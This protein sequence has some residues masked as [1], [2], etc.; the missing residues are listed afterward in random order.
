MDWWGVTGKEVGLGLENKTDVSAT[1][2]SPDG[3]TPPRAELQ[4]S[5]R[6]G[7]RYSDVSTQSLRHGMGYSINGGWNRPPRRLNTVGETLQGMIKK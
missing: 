5:P 2:Q 3:S 1:Q 4:S 7:G 6:A